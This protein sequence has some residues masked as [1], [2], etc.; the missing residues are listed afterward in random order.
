M[1]FLLVL[2]H[3]FL[4]VRYDRYFEACERALRR[5]VRKAHSL[6]LELPLLGKVF[7]HSGALIAL[8]LAASFGLIVFRVHGCRM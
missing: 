1:N 3:E 7:E 2:R 8:L 6:K 5:V 4:L